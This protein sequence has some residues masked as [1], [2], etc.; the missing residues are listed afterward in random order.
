MSAD[1]E[2]DVFPG[3]TYPYTTVGDWVL[4]APISDRAVRVYG[5]LRMHV[6]TK[7]GDDRVWPSQ[8]KIAAVLGLAKIDPVGKAVQELVALGAVDTRYRRTPRGRRLEYRVHLAPPDGYAGPMGTPDLHAEGAMEAFAEDRVRR[9]PDRQNGR[10]SGVTPDPGGSPKRTT[11]DPVVRADKPPDP[12]GPIPPDPGCELN[13]REPTEGT[14]NS[15][16]DLKSQYVGGEDRRSTSVND[17][18]VSNARASG[19]PRPTVQQVNAAQE[20][21]TRE[22][23]KAQAATL[24]ERWATASSVTLLDHQRKQ[25]EWEVAKHLR[26]GMSERQ[27]RAGLSH[28]RDAGRY[29]SRDLA[30][31]IQKAIIESEDPLVTGR[32]TD[33]KASE[34]LG[35]ESEPRLPLELRQLGA[36]VVRELPLPPNGDPWSRS[37]PPIIDDAEWVAANTP[38]PPDLT[39]LREWYRTVLDPWKAERRERAMR[40]LQAKADAHARVSQ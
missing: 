31:H 25:H 28:W 22:R 3:R 29:R 37:R 11:H 36:P 9:F 32:I 40:V 18:Y 1:E 23:R 4:L 35:Y 20:E 15:S 10:S 26:G 30:P 34:V 38:P 27:I 24:V 13:E 16:H 2:F 6:N 14:S 19:D 17:R 21:Q 39:P 7:R 33:E 5:L 8:M 12:G